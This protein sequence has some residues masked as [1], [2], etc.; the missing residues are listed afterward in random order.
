MNNI[1]KR[2]VLFLFGCILLRSIFVIIAKTKIEYLPYF[3][4]VALLP[5]IGWLYIY[6]TDS[7]KT[8]PEVFGQSIWWNNL[9]PVHALLY[10]LFAISAFMKKDFSWMFLLADVLLGLSAFLYHHLLGAPN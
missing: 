4:A 5:V 3:G 8:G 7:R 9:R 6:F 1:Q 10:L 2:F